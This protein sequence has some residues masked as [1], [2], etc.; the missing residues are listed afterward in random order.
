MLDRKQPKITSSGLIDGT[1][2]SIRGSGPP[3]IL[4]HGLGMHKH[5][6]LWQIPDLA[7]SFTIVTYDILGHGASKSPEENCSLSEFVAQLHSLISGLN[8]QQVSVVG[9]SLG[10]MIARA[11]VLKYPQNIKTLAILHSAHDR[12]QEERDA[13][14]LRVNQSFEA[15]PSA[16]V[17]DAINRWFSPNF[18]HNNPDIMNFVKDAILAN[19]S[20]IYHIIYRVLAM[21]D[22]ELSNQ[23]DQIA[24]PTLVMTGDKDNG[25]SPDM[26]RRMAQLIPNATIVIL[27]GMRHMAMIE[28]P[29]AFNSHLLKFLKKYYDN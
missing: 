24:C 12:T 22:I 17:N 10:G 11:Y 29:D 21:A 8:L 6:W 9:F 3:L 16:T 15:G 13:I 20:N 18:Q 25:N 14:L 2:Y 27:K 1:S 28:D 26:A 4:I 5:M 7:N 19:D 23:I